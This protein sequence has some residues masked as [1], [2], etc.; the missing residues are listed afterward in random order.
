M[1]ANP[2][3]IPED[4]AGALGVM[5]KP[6]T[7]NGLISA[8]SFVADTLEAGGEPPP[9]WSLQLAPSF[10]AAEDGRFRISR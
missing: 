3:R 7:T 6:Y 1:T 10:L 9:P 2:K 4:F 8:V 5:G